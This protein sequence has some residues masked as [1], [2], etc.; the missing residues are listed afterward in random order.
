VDGINWIEFLFIALDDSLCVGSHQVWFTWF[1]YFRINT[2]TV[3]SLHAHSQALLFH[4]H[5]FRR[6]ISLFSSL[7]ILFRHYCLVSQSIILCLLGLEHVVPHSFLMEFV[8]YHRLTHNIIFRGV[9]KVIDV[10][11]YTRIKY[12]GFGVVIHLYKGFDFNLS[13]A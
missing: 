7:V 3:S 5:F 6:L 11:R 2:P 13:Q 10:F 9:E 1:H 4:S 8:Y 12:D